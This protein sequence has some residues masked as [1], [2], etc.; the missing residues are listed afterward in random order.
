MTRRIY[1]GSLLLAIVI[2]IN[3]GTVVYCL[4]IFYCTNK[5]VGCETYLLKKTHLCLI[6]IFIPG[7][8]HK[9]DAR[10]FLININISSLESE[11]LLIGSQVLDNYGD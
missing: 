7:V 5:H 10:S 6:L 2:G 3:T 9:F 4:R 11:F 8:K 1:D